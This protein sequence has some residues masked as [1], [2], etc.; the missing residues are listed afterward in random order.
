LRRALAQF[1]IRGGVPYAV[2]AAV[3]IGTYYFAYASAMSFSQR[4]ASP[5]WLPDSVLLCAL[6]ATPPRV[7]WL[8]ILATLPI[9]FFA[10]VSAGIPTWFLLATF[11]LDAAKGLVTAVV[12]RRFV[13]DPVR[14][15]YLKE[16][17]LFC[18]V[19]VLLVP[20][21]SAF[22]GAAAR[23]ALGHEYW[24]AW[25][26]WF[27]GDATTNLVITPAILY[28]IFG[29][30]WKLP[31]SFGAR[32]AEAA[33]LGVLLI[34]TAH[35]AFSVRG[36]GAGFAESRFFAPLPFLFWAGARFGMR[37][38]SGAI[39]IVALTAIAAALQRRGIFS[40]RGPEEIALALQDYLLVRAAPLYLVAVLVEESR[41]IQ[42]SLRESEDR[43]RN[44]ADTAPVLI[45]ISDRDKQCQFFNQ[46]WLDFTGRKLEQERGDGWVASVHPD[47]VA[48]CR[49]VFRSSFDARKPFEIEY[50]LRRCD[51]E[52]RWILDRGVPR[53]GPNSDFL[54]YIGSAI[55]ITDRKLAEEANL[56]LAHMQRLAV[57]GELTAMIAHEVRQPMTAILSNADAATKLLELP[58][59]P[60]DEIHEII[61]DIRNDDLRADAA[62]RRIRALLQKRAPHMQ[63]LD[64]N[65]SVLEVLELVA[66]DAVRRRVQ[67]LRE[68][69][70][71]LPPAF[72][73]ATQMQQVLLNLVVNAMDALEGTPP[74]SCKV[75]VRT[76]R[77]GEGVEVEV[78][79]FGCGIAEDRLPS[80]FD[81][82]FTTRADGMGLGLSIARSI[83]R[84]HRGRIEAENNPEGGAT[85]RFS[86]PG[87]VT[88]KAEE[89]R[90]LPELR[91]S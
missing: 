82:F 39:T 81:A 42:D 18:L 85:F 49:A 10:P 22:G 29:E 58:N 5:F 88:V 56:Q 62:I 72:G 50:R 70:P 77:G 54:G 48:H 61:T 43:F 25:E 17:A 64:L 91:A 11:A 46:G 19:A 38:A 3:Y 28:W 65:K 86:I 57:S 31:P 60:L 52:Y 9:R 44:M 89:P 35:I 34:I 59:P 83:I 73:D 66:G 16:F 8:L 90:S 76:H 4:V 75:I 37:G 63:E 69:D 27:L 24:P 47:D 2:A 71:A 7:W 79:D 23:H 15:R 80:L 36:P 21:A 1:D 33:L 51:G 45:W 32:F 68:L 87:A 78:S 67:V 55:D 6:L 53:Y 40:G 12:L 74:S 84:A 26:Q 13:E 14:I 20:A 41:A 30:P